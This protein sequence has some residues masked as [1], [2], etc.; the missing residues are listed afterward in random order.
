MSTTQM[1]LD[2]RLGGGQ[3]GSVRLASHLG[4]NV[5][6]RVGCPLLCSKEE[7]LLQAPVCDQLVPYLTV[8]RSGPRLLLVTPLLCCSLAHLLS[9]GLR[10]TDLQLGW[11]LGQVVA[12]L[13]CL[14]RAGL[15]HGSL[16]AASLLVSRGGEVKLGD[17]GL[18]EV[19]A[20]AFSRQWEVPQPL[21]PEGR[22]P[23]RDVWALGVLI[24]E[25]VLGGRLPYRSYRASSDTL[26]SKI[27]DIPSL[28]APALL[29]A[30]SCLQ[31]EPTLRP[32]LP[33]VASL[34]WLAEQ[35]QHPGLVKEGLQLLCLAAISVEEQEDS[36]GL[37]CS[38]C[39][40][41]TSYGAVFLHEERIFL[42]DSCLEGDHGECEVQGCGQCGELGA[43]LRSR[44][45]RQRGLLRLKE[46][47]EGQGR[48]GKE[49]LVE[50]EKYG[51]D[52][53]DAKDE[54][55]VDE[56]K[57]EVKDKVK[58]KVKDIEEAQN[59][60]KGEED[61]ISRTAVRAVGGT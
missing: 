6:V 47:L 37:Q 1:R 2:R 55:D 11:V 23:A 12:G 3:W 28:P 46:D 52:I 40:Q 9:Q 58:D 19:L 24:A 51:A 32:S 57:A 36:K 45:G 34:P 22:G 18:A 38:S 13:G 39:G 41:G 44:W 29:L 31:S 50:E 61:Y 14:H 21:Q 8:S 35:G 27:K 16:R 20:P 25:M 59:I 43:R 33:S 60:G 54:L 30:Q 10:L 5:V 4:S 53:E 26:V 42:C 7:L 48:W 15:E 56:V 17:W 49:N